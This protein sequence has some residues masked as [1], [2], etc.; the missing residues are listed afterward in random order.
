MVGGTGEFDTDLMKAVPR[1]F[2]KTGAEGVYCACIPHAGLGIALKCDDGAGR[3][4]RVAIASVLSS[5]NVWTD[6]E[7][8]TLQHFRHHGLKNW[9]KIHVGE[10]RAVN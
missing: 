5:L 10:V 2:V 7:R 3:A 6:E 1:V 9:R 8:E 4:A